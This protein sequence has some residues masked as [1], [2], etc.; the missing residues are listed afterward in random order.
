MKITKGFTLIEILV[1]L[2]AASIISIMS[3]EFLSNSV[4]LKERVDANIKRD[5]DH[6]NTINTIRLDLMQ[7]VPFDMKDQN[8]RE[9]KV[10]FVGNSLNR[11]MTFVSL[12]TSDHLQTT[13]KLRR[14]IYLYEDNQLIRVTTLSNKEQVEISRKTLI[15]NVEN[16]EIRFGE[17]LDEAEIDWPNLKHNSNIKFPKYIFLT[18]EIENSIYKQVFSTFR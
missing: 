6:M 17:E 5:S 15:K 3:F 12:S 9:L 18:Y 10:S 7:A 14:V 8:G 4:F 11:V 13:S 2:L 1:A 16:L